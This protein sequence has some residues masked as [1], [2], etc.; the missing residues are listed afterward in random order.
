MN[1]E[2]NIVS[3]IYTDIKVNINLS[4]VYYSIL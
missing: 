1:I 2:I 4:S 3:H